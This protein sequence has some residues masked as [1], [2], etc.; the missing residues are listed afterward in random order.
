MY[1]VESKRYTVQYICKEKNYVFADLLKF[2]IGKH[3]KRSGP[4]IANPQRAAFAE[5]PQ[6]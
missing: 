4:Q 2:E 5:G 1:N 6:I 3:N